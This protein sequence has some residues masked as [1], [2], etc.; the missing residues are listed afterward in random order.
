MA[1]CAAREV[2]E[3]TG[4]KIRSNTD[5]SSEGFSS[6][7]QHPTPF[8]AVDSISRDGTG[9]FK[10]HYVVVEV[11]AMAAEPDGEPVANDDVNAVQWLDVNKLRGLNNL[12]R[13]CARLAEEARHRFDLSS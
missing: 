13:S 11:A 8:A 10:F 2:F 1:E 3:E 12:T 4:V 9:R 5:M 6:T 7:L